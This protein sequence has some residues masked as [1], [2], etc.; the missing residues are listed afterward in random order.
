MKKTSIIFTIV[1]ILSILLTACVYSGTDS[2][3]I[4]VFSVWEA[5]KNETCTDEGLYVRSCECGEKET[6]IIP[7]KGHDYLSDWTIDL[8]ATCTTPGSKSHHC[9]NCDTK[10]DITEIPAKGHDYGEWMI[11]EEATCTEDGAKQ[12]ICSDCGNVDI[13]IIASEGHNYSSDW[14]IDVPASCTT[15]GS[16]S[17]H[18]IVCDF[19]GDVT[20][21][22]ANGHDYGEWMITEEATCAEDGA[23]QRT[24]STCGKIEIETI[25][26]TGHTYTD[27]PFSATKE[28]DAYIHHTCSSCGYEYTEI[29]ENT[30]G[31]LGLEYSFNSDSNTAT[32]QG[33]GTC[34]DQ[35]IVIPQVVNNYL[36][37][38]ISSEAFTNCSIMTSITIPD[39]V[40][41]IGAYAF[42]NCSSLTT[43]LLPNTINSVG[44]YSFRGC[45]SL[46]KIQLP[47][48]PH[49]NDIERETIEEIIFNGN[50]IRFDSFRGY[51]N[52]KKITFTDDLLTFDGGCFLDCPNIETVIVESGNSKFDSRNNCNGIIDTASN[53]LIWGVS[54][55]S[56]PDTVTGI[57][58]Y[59]FQGC[60]AL[61]SITIPSQIT[62][63]GYGVFAECSGL[64][65]IS[66]D[67]NN[68]VYDS[69]N[70]CN[71]IISTSGNSLIAG[72]Q[73]TTIPN[74][75]VR[76]EEAAFYGCDSLTEIV[77]PNSVT[78]IGIWAFENCT[79]LSKVSLSN[80]LETIDEMVFYQCS[81]LTEIVLPEGIQSIGYG[82]FSHTGLTNISFPNSLT[83]IDSYAFFGSQLTSVVIPDGN[84]QIDYKAFGGTA[85]SATITET[86]SSTSYRSTFPDEFLKDQS[87]DHQEIYKFSFDDL[88][89][90]NGY[91]C[92]TLV[93]ISVEGYPGLIIVKSSFVYV[94]SDSK[95]VNYSVG[96]RNHKVFIQFVAE[97]GYCYSLDSDNYKGI[98]YA[99]IT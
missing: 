24:C 17:H 69:R 64:V 8:P 60:S 47:I 62:H 79:H 93:C 57:G 29:L 26:A 14:T 22:P 33:I 63:I 78:S 48:P 61:T 80:S 9:K 7:A 13:Q 1:S 74:D 5:Q 20:E 52:L 50:R 90:I 34:T 30:K 45:S 75:V 58:D 27:T 3:H 21:I 43:L 88:S 83:Q 32:V 49:Y 51:P 91:T 4:H 55:T 98:L 68:T 2:T 31:S 23:K 96:H 12:R 38:G 36:V 84:I 40:T 92:N 19:K 35:E 44:Q 59:A 70:D 72:C 94:M 18:C 28:T 53:T 11:T 73:N 46:K 81:A 99:L 97:P 10:A 56:I 16:K 65:S 66:V 71:A 77:I 89:Y 76:I 85:I 37:T 82:A 15:P 39:S 87:N 86:P 67:S 54:T 6:K 95:L 42:A 41:S 25:P